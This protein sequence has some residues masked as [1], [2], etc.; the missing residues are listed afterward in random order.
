MRHSSSIWLFNYVNVYARRSEQFFVTGKK[1]TFK[2][3][4]YVIVYVDIVC[5]KTLEYVFNVLWT[6]TL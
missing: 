6:C 3:R 4:D 1:L 2:K 5:S